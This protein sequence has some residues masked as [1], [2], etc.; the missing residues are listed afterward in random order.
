[1][2]TYSTSIFL[3]KKCT[4]FIILMWMMV[5][6]KVQRYLRGGHEQRMEIHVGG[7]EKKYK[8]RLHK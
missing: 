6:S 1:M 7:R 3:V 2:C 5:R 8:G 4:Y